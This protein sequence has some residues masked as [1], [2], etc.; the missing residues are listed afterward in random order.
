MSV[1]V[2]AP[3]FPKQSVDEWNPDK[4]IWVWFLHNWSHNDELNKE[5]L[6]CNMAYEKRPDAYAHFWSRDEHNARDGR[7]SE[8]KQITVYEFL[9]Q[10]HEEG[11]MVANPFEGVNFLRFLNDWTNEWVVAKRQGKWVFK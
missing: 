8:L 10:L 2:L 7:W 6:I 5:P 9:K 4:V 1:K 11:G 3:G